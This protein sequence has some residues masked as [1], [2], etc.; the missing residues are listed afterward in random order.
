LM[1]RRSVLPEPVAIQKAIFDRSPS[2]NSLI[3]PPRS[4]SLPYSVRNMF[5]DARSSGFLFFSSSR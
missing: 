3:Q 4:C 5:N 2:M 1:W